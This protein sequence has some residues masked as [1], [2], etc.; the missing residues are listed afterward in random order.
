MPRHAITRRAALVLAGATLAR[1]ALA[2]AQPQRIAAIDWAMLETALALGVTPV[3]ATELIQ[4]RRQVVVP[5]TPESVTDLGLRGTPNFELLRIVQPDL[6]LISNFYEHLRPIYERIAPVFSATVFRPGEPPYP[7]AEQATAA[8]GERLG[9]AREAGSL[10]DGTR[11]ELAAIGERLA[12]VERRPIFV[13][14]L[15]DARHFRAFGDDS[16][17]G[18][19]LGLLG[20]ANAWEGASSYSAAAPVGI[21]ALARVPEA[22]LIAVEPTPPEVR[23]ALATSAL[24]RSLPMVREDRVAFMEPVNHFGALPSAERFARLLDALL[25]GTKGASRG[26]ASRG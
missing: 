11:R 24:W 2:G 1:P 23:R 9:L 3:A 22:R 17:F 26:G 4:F 6:I 25:R 12:G 10:I 5:A 16:L 13:A 21:E 18:N 7:R 20:L 8:L 19:V 15:G 14:S